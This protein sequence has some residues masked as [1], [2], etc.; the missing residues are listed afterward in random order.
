VA[1]LPEDFAQAAQQVSYERL[2]FFLQAGVA[3]SRL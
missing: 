3:A 1:F 2:A